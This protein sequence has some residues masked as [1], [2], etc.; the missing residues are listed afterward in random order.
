[1]TLF[2]CRRWQRFALFATRLAL[3]ALLG[4]SRWWAPPQRLHSVSWWRSWGSETMASTQASSKK[5]QLT[6]LQPPVPAARRMSASE[7]QFAL[8]CA[9]CGC[10]GAIHVQPCSS[11]QLTSGK[12]A[13]KRAFCALICCTEVANAEW[14]LHSSPHT[15]AGSS[16]LESFHAHCLNWLL[17]WLW[18]CTSH[19]SQG[20]A[21]LM[22]FV[23]AASS[24]GP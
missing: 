21:A 3:R 10:Q 16:T 9:A 6:P 1:M 8:C 13:Q 20:T 17:R 12:P 2:A 24:A 7:S 11:M 23:L 5:G 4:S 15:S 18:T 22:A 19:Q 14:Q